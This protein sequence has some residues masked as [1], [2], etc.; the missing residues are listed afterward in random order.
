MRR[1]LLALLVLLLTA[2]AFA[3]EPVRIP[4]ECE[5]MQGVK[6]GPAGFTADWTFGKWGRDL[7]QN[8][9]F[10]GV[11]A[12]RMA[13]AVTDAG[14]NPAAIYQD[15]EVPRDDRYKVWAKYECP[16]NFNYPFAIRIERLENDKPGAKVFE[17]TYGLRTAAKHYCFTSDVTT[18]DLYWAWGI[19]HDA[20]EGYET[21]LKA[22]RYRVT[23]TKVPG[24]APV[25]QRSVDAIL[26]TTK[27]DKVSA[28]NYTR[29]PLLDELRQI[30]HMYFRFT[31]TGK[32]PI[33]LAYNHWGH[34]YEDFYTMQKTELARF[35]DANG[36]M[37][38]DDKGNPLALPNAQWN[39]PLAPGESSPWVDLGPTMN[40][41]SGSPFWAQALDAQGKPQTD[42][43]FTMD[44][45]LSPSPAAIAKSFAKAAEE[46]MLVVNV[47]PDLHRKEGQ[48]YTQTSRDVYNRMTAEMNAIPRVGPMP[49]KLRLFGAV[50]TV[51]PGPV[52]PNAHGGDV[53]LKTVAD[54]SI[55]LGLNTY[56]YAFSNPDYA[57]ALSAYYQSKNAPLVELSGAFHHTQ[58]VKDLQK[59]TDPR[60]KPRFYYSSF[61]DEIGLPPVNIN[62]Q[63]QLAAFRA[64]AQQ[65]GVKPQDLGFKTWEEVKP[66][67]SYTPDAAVGV[68]LLPTGGKPALPTGNAALPLKRLFWLTHGFVI[69]RGV[70]DFAKKTQEMTALFGPQFKTSAN[71]G[72]MH[73]FYWLHQSSFIESFSGGAMTLAWSEDYDYTQ[74][75]ASRLC[76]E[77]QAANLRCGAKYHDTPMMF[78]NMPHFPGN[79]GRHLVQNAVSLWGQNVK[80]LDFFSVSPDLFSTENYLASRG[81]IETAAGIRRISGM[82][83]NVE[84]ALLP[85]RTR[86]AKVAMLLSEASDLWEV[87]AGSQW[88]V[89]PDS[90][91][92]NAFN[93]ERKAIW[94]ALRNAG[95]LVDLLTENDVNE[96]R[97]QGY[98][99][100][101]VCGRNL[102]RRTAAR[103]QGWVK[104]GGVIY[105]TAGA[106]RFD[107]FD[108]PLIA[109]DAL[110]GRGPVVKAD[111]Y[112]GPLRAKLELPLL[113]PKGRVTL[114]LN[115]QQ[116]AYD[117][118]ASVENFKAAKGA[119]VLGTFAGGQPALVDMKTGNGWGFYNGTLPGQA[120]LKKAMPLRVMGKGGLDDN[121]CHFEPQDFDENAAAAIL[122]PVRQAGL[123]PEVTSS[124]RHI[125]TSILDGPQATVVTMID[126]G[127][128]EPTLV[129]HGRKLL[130]LTLRDVRPAKSVRTAMKAGVTFQN[131]KDGVT[132]LLTDIHDADLIVVEH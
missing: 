9:V 113:T 13:A 35:Y 42:A 105:L 115:K 51:Y 75:E 101:Y 121:Y 100:L 63:A 59:F 99:V 3:A 31:N 68:G 124:D 12:S 112:Q 7:H 66:L 77:Y 29:Y 86:K 56:G 104:G 102:E 129:G 17:Q 19:D 127:R 38:K 15:I 2:L 111:Y 48:D 125:I 107:E 44:I 32:T 97:L 76:I 10:G 1:S 40:V 22:G 25:G 5:D 74:P 114:T 108:A 120:W 47:M 24:P 54:Y 93:E 23:M 78:Y 83:G 34:R 94:Y 8:M 14:N 30:N 18:G 27:L 81:G 80:D 53:A 128:H 79:T 89:K 28:P 73:P 55:A 20:A 58:D 4:I 98:K 16:P 43:P 96:G 95:Y 57:D 41:E 122:L 106:A 36:Q 60:I 64:F 39:K 65:H 126:L 90:V 52:A 69:E 85:A 82:A 72:G 123:Q 61:G 71:L 45:A 119:K 87:C 109:L 62:D 11:W 110:V 70:A 33:T 49:K 67:A 116:L 92:T 46:P 6:V 37:L 132:V 131:G 50:G 118:Y 117:A 91:A 26:I 88:D 84:D 103:L 130:S 21:D